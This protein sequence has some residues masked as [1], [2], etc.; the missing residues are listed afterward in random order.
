MS[1]REG[2]PEADPGPARQPAGKLHPPA[3]L[4]VLP[5]ELEEVPGKRDDWVSMF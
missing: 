1:N 4:G 2:G 5:E 3:G